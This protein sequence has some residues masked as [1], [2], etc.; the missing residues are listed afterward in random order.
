[1]SFLVSPIPNSVA[2]SGPKVPPLYIMI[3][4]VICKQI[5]FNPMRQITLRK[6]VL[7]VKSTTHNQS[8]IA[9]GQSLSTWISDSISSWQNLHVWLPIPILCFLALFTPSIHIWL[10]A[11]TLFPSLIDQ[12]IFLS[13]AGHSFTKPFQRH[14]YDDFAI[15]NSTGTSLR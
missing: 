7:A 11:P 6:L 13:I 8:A 12:N 5:K 2:N 14:E 3:L 10:Q 9:F 1:M 4:V 15:N